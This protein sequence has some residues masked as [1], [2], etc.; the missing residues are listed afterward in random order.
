M[1]VECRCSVYVVYMYAYNECLYIIYVLYII[2]MYTL[3]SA[4]T[5]KYISVYIMNES[6]CNI[7]IYTVYACCSCTGYNYICIL[8]YI[9]IHYIC[10][11]YIVYV[12]IIYYICIYIIQCARTRGACRV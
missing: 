4:C 1:P 12:Y 8:F 9:H 3:Y 11:I 6:G 2:Y 10:F 5:L 7:Y